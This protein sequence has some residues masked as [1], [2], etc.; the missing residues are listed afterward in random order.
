MSCGG[1]V[2]YK[3]SSDSRAVD[4][5]KVEPLKLLTCIIWGLGMESLVSGQSVQGADRRG[6]VR[7][8]PCYTEHWL[9]SISTPVK[10]LLSPLVFCKTQAEH[11]CWKV[12]WQSSRKRSKSSLCQRDVHTRRQRQRLKQHLKCHQKNRAKN[13]HRPFVVLYY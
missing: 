9:L 2:K 7:V 6:Q 1:M 3:F 10:Q 8:R 13:R 12:Q 4:S 5:G 11:E